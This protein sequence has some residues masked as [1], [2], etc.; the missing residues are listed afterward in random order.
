MSDAPRRLRHVVIRCHP[1]QD[2]LNAAMAAAY[3]TEVEQHGH[4]VVLRD[5]Y[6][7]GFDPVLKSSERP[8]MAFR[9]TADVHDELAV[10]AGADVFVLVYPIWFGGPPAMLKGYIERVLGSTAMPLQFA[11]EASHGI[12]TGK[13]LVTFSTSA[14]ESHWLATQGQMQSLVAGFDRY[15]EHG[16]AMQ[17]SQH[18]HFGGIT[19]GMEP[20][21]ITRI[22][23]EVTERARVLCLNLD[24]EGR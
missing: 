20:G 24:R 23:H 6:A 15:I 16:F 11:Q 3:T 5:L 12:L 8:G 7:M 22:L 2:S 1:D 17:P 4:E 21:E 10:I 14:T 9:E 13:R 19:A 18:Y